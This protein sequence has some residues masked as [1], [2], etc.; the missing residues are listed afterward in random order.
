MNSKEEN[1]S[2]TKGNI[3]EH[4]HGLLTHERKLKITAVKIKLLKW[5]KFTGICQ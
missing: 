4:I 1:N 3:I 2:I 5:L